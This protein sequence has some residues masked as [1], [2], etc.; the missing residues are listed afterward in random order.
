MFILFGTFICQECSGVVPERKYK[1]KEYSY[2][3]FVKK[4]KLNLHC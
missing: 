2:D 3:S 4:K 1:T